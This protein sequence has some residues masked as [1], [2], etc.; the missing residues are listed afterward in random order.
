M[1]GLIEMKS[2][3]AAALT[4]HSPRNKMLAT[5]VLWLMPR[6]KHPVLRVDES[7]PNHEV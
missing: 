2:N 4:R 1:R 7:T 3:W 5:L 6:R